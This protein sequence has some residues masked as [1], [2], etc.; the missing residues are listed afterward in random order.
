MLTNLKVLDVDRP[1][2]SENAA[3]YR[4]LHSEGDCVSGRGDQGGAVLC[5]MGCVALFCGGSSCTGRSTFS[6]LP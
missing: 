5:V 2:L 4:R 1:G 6:F 3:D